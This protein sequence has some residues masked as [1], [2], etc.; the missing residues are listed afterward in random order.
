MWNGAHSKLDQESLSGSIVTVIVTSAISK[1]IF[2]YFA[3]V[4]CSED[5]VQVAKL[6][7][8]KHLEILGCVRASKIRDAWECSQECSSVVE[9]DTILLKC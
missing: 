8:S 9:H 7:S 1:P 6:Y 3:R 2:F 5:T 4:L